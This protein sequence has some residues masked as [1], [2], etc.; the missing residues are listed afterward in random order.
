ML[1]H[2]L[3]ICWVFSI[4]DRYENMKIQL[5]KVEGYKKNFRNSNQGLT[6]DL[7]LNLNLTESYDQ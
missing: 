2:L 5:Q 3:I 7:N 1:M 6:M 4:E